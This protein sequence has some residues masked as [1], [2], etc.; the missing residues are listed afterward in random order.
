MEFFVLAC[1][2]NNVSK[3]KFM[4]F[5]MP[6]KVIPCLSFSINGNYKL[7]MSIILTF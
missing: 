6:Q 2:K 1:T 5:H 3:S 4:L 7:R